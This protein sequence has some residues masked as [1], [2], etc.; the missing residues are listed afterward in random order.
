MVSYEIPTYDLSLT[1]VHSVLSV[2]CF[3]W[4]SYITE[5]GDCIAA[6][7][8]NNNWVTAEQLSSLETADM[9]NLLI[10][11]LNFYYSGEVHSI[12]DLSMREEV[13]DKGSLCGM[14]ALYQAARQTLLTV[15]QIKQMSF[16]DVK[17]VLGEEM[18]YDKTETIKLS[19]Y[20]LM[21]LYH[22]CKV[23]PVML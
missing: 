9:K 23:S 15:S 4:H 14:S 22:D 13:G 16:S 6:S 1:P 19:D 3:A 5:G 8:L 21:S 17:V 11:K 2:E 12:V 10:K 18:G 20:D 7:L